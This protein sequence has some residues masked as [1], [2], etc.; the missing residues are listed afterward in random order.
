MSDESKTT[1]ESTKTSSGWPIGQLQ[2]SRECARQVLGLPDRIETDRFVDWRGIEDHWTKTI[3]KQVLRIVFQDE[4]GTLKIFAD[5][6][7]HSDIHAELLG[8]FAGY[9]LE[10]FDST[11]RRAP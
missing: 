8:L 5:R 4:S 11:A 9:D 7:E 6:Q 3:S 1:A 10:I 2:I